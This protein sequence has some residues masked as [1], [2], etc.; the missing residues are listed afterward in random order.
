VGK[1]PPPVPVKKI[2]TVA[3]SADVKSSP[4]ETS[5]NG[6]QQSTQTKKVVPIKGLKG[7][8]WLTKNERL[9]VLSE[10]NLPDLAL[11]LPPTSNSNYNLTVV[12][13]SRAMGVG[14]NERRSCLKRAILE[15]SVPPSGPWMGVLKGGGGDLAH[16]YCE[17]LVRGYAKGKLEI[18][19]LER[20]DY[21]VQ[22]DCK[23]P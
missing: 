19:D 10:F 12:D 7:K 1:L 23:L 20:L 17:D 14:E 22:Y 18:E 6:Q 15:G 5:V 21:M 4:L 3:G 11:D 16:S 13:L 9:K 2:E 8:T